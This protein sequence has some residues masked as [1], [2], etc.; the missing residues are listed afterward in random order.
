MGRKDSTVNQAEIL[1]QI[2]NLMSKTDVEY[3]EEQLEKEWIPA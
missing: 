3:T 2:R 1:G